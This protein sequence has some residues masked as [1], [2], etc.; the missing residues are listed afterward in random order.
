MQLEIPDWVIER[1]VYIFLGRECW[2]VYEPDENQWYIKTERC[3][4]CGKCCRD[5]PDDWQHGV[6]EI[7]G[8]RYCA[9]IRE[10]GG[11]WWCEAKNAPFGCSKDKPRKIPHPD[12]VMRYEKIKTV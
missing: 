1:R 2:M 9:G 7:D 5:V 12:C 4:K 10:A 6:Q 8:I 3:N 11:E